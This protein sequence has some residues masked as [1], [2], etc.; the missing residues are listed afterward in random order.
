MAARALSGLISYSGL[1]RSESSPVIEH[2]WR[3]FIGEEQPEFNYGA[4]KSVVADEVDIEFLGVW[5][6]VYGFNRE[7][8]LK[9][10]AFMKLRFRDFL[11]D[12]KVKVGIHILSIDDTRK[13]FHPM[14]WS[15][16][17]AYNRNQKME[18]IWMPGVHSDVGGGYSEDFISTVSL[19]TMMDKLSQYCPDIQ[20]EQ[21]Y[22]KSYLLST[23]RDKNKIINDEWRGYFAIGDFGRQRKCEN[24]LT[25][26]DQYIHPL[27]DAFRGKP[28][29]I[30]RT[31]CEYAPS[32]LLS[33]SMIKLPTAT[34]SLKSYNSDYIKQILSMI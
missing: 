4:M 27:V 20:Y 17:S 25:D 28:M 5:D 31:R 18:Q 29:Q 7:G 34:F 3:Y 32:F 2:A 23:L 10:S 16:R 6:T 33:N 1:V 12:R 19:L 15:G 8:A 14:L 11:L 13:Y 30:K 9:R 21:E 24:H 22:T 26:L